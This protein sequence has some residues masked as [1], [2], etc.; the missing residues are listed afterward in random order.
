MRFVLFTPDL[1]ETEDLFLLTRRSVLCYKN[2]KMSS[3]EDVSATRRCVVGVAMPSVVSLST[4]KWLWGGSSH[5]IGN[6]ILV[7]RA[8]PNEVCAFHPGSSGNGR[9]VFVK[10]SFSSLQHKRDNVLG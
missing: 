6:Y 2:A 9:F 10:S 1:L 8:A 3:V 5:L 4:P 7:G